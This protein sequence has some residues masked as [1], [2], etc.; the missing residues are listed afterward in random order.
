MIHFDC[1]KVTEN[2]NIGVSDVI[3]I[4]ELLEV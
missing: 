3:S 2:E 1:V 4:G